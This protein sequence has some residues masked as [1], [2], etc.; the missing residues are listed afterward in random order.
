MKFLLGREQ[1]GFSDCKHPKDVKRLFNIALS[2]G[3][4]FPCDEIESIWQEFSYTRNAAWLPVDS[5]SA[6]D[7]LKIIQN[8]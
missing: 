8:K 1:K 7:L 6:A 5:F 2:N 4:I 3:Y